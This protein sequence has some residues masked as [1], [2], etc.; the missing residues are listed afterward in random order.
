M[1]DFFDERHEHAPPP[2]VV[3]VFVASESTFPYRN[4][5]RMTGDSSCM[6]DPPNHVI[7]L[8]PSRNSFGESLAFFAVL[9]PPL[10]PRLT[11]KKIAFL[12]SCTPQYLLKDSLLVFSRRRTSPADAAREKDSLMTNSFPVRSMILPRRPMLFLLL[13]LLLSSSSPFPRTKDSTSRS[14]DRTEFAAGATGGRMEDVRFGMDMDDD[15]DVSPTAAAT[16]E[17]RMRFPRVATC[18]LSPASVKSL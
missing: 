2:A 7:R 11:H 14:M 18:C 9:L 12:H 8:A 5:L 15:D 6:R 17:L 3:A 1:L 4:S 16:G 10:P 13:L